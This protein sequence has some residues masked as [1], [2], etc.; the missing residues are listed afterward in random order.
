MQKIRVLIYTDQHNPKED[1]KDSDSNRNMVLEPSD[2][3]Q[4]PFG[5]SL[6]RDLI[7][8]QID[9]GIEVEVTLANRNIFDHHASR[10]TAELLANYEELWVFGQFQINMPAYS[11]SDGGPHNELDDGEVEALREWM[12][13]GGGVLITGD[14]SE[15]NPLEGEIGLLN[16]GRALGH[17]IPRAGEMREWNGGPGPSGPTSINSQSPG[18]SEDLNATSL[19][20]DAEPQHIILEPDRIKCPNECI[21]PHKL[22]S[23][24]PAGR[25]LV[26]PDHT[27]EGKLRRPDITGKDW[28]PGGSI[29]P[30]T[31]AK[32]F[33]KRFCPPRIYDLVSVY[34][35]HPLKVG[36][37]VADNSW[38]HYLNKNLRSLRYDPNDPLAPRNQIGKYYAN[39][40]CWLAPPQIH[41]KLALAKLY[42][43]ATHPRVLEVAGSGPL[44]LG[45]AAR[46][47]TYMERQPYEVKNILK[48]NIPLEMFQREGMDNF[49]L[50]ELCLGSLIQRC[51]EAIRVWGADAEERLIQEMKSESLINDKTRRDH[52]INQLIDQARHF[53]DALKFQT[54][55]GPLVKNKDHSGD[56][57][58][59]DKNTK[60]KENE[61][62]DFVNNRW[63]SI[64]I[65]TTTN[66]AYVEG[67]LRITEDEPPGPK[68]RVFHPKHKPYGGYVLGTISGTDQDE[69]SF[70]ITLDDGNAIHCSY[71][72]KL[73]K[74]VLTGDPADGYIR[75]LIVGKYHTYMGQPAVMAADDDGGWMAT[76]PPIV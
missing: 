6:M 12:N 55:S 4:S 36:R 19:E 54:V 60:N 53:G 56:I 25:I 32:G 71:S 13:A 64:V 42:R 34:D 66:N 65:G 45:K 30:F 74:V 43:F 20:Q 35:G 2:P 1:G 44:V 61:M 15:K 38:H 49:L 17:R 22:F 21:E 9:K 39:L 29:H 50:E 5:L 59:A 28:P 72:G 18:N 63:Q 46:Q 11:V 10:I 8:T 51:H 16:Y 31:V 7:L 73:K 68:V 52:E 24:G 3:F 67:G 76:R 75:D 23:G 48:A 26:F 70:T 62:S 57:G 37:I 69:I 33:D 41:E 47:V 58:T 14:H 40:T 27:H